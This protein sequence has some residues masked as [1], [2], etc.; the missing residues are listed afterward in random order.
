MQTYISEGIGANAEI[1]SGVRYVESTLARALS[2]GSRM[3]V[4]SWKYP[5]LILYISLSSA[6]HLSLRLAQS[7]HYDRLQ[8]LLLQAEQ[9]IRKGRFPCPIWLLD[10]EQGYCHLLA[11]IVS[12]LVPVEMLPQK[13][14]AV[15][16]FYIQ[17]LIRDGLHRVQKLQLRD[18][19][20]LH[21]QHLVR[22]LC[23]M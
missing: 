9:L 2:Q 11:V 16:E 10:S 22:R 23:L 13:R 8:I 21:E 14:F 20:T 6:V 17:T 5:D 15:D 3:Y 7:L 18:A 4:S 12:V 1:L 19:D